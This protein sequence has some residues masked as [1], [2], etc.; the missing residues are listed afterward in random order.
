M[1]LPKFFVIILTILYI[2]LH[3]NHHHDH[4]VHGQRLYHPSQHELDLKYFKNELNTSYGL[5]LSG[6]FNF[7]YKDLMKLL[8]DHQHHDHHHDTLSNVYTIDVG[9]SKVDVR[10]WMVDIFKKHLVKVEEVEDNR[11]DNTK[12]RLEPMVLFIYNAQVI[13]QDIIKE[14]I[15]G[16]W[17][18]RVGMNCYL[19]NMPFQ[20]FD[21]SR[22]LIIFSTNIG[23]K[24][25]ILSKS[26]DI[27]PRDGMN[28]NLNS[29][30][31]EFYNKFSKIYSLHGGLERYLR[32]I[33]INDK[34]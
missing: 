31:T 17:N 7:H 20:V 26:I 29:V 22:L 27:A 14:I 15:V 32:F 1:V 6:N 34:G 5:F 24:S 10:Q 21:C 9:M 23:Y 12:F 19:G 4:Q 30:F 16:L 25:V 8:K 3:D 28:R 2:T 18:K 11:D 33:G 13:E